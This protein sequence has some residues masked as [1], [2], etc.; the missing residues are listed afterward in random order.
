MQE[1]IDYDF[2]QANESKNI[3]VPE[4]SDGKT[5]RRSGKYVPADKGMAA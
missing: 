5:L 2:Y 3:R 4:Q 1:R